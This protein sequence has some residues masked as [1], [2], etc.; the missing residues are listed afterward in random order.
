MSEPVF[1]HGT[2]RG[3]SRG[4][5][6]MPKRFHQQQDQTSAPL[7]PGKE[8]ARDSDDW[9]YVTTSPELAWVY[10]WCAPGRGKPKVLVVEPSGPIE[11]DPEHSPGMEAYR[12]SMAKVVAVLKDPLVTEQEA[13]EGWQEAV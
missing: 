3:F 10:A 2:R 8:R 7:I 4:G 5:F 11:R 1:Y 6:L 12:T 13:R 9:V